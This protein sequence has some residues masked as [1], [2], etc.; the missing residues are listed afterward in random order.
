MAMYKPT[1]LREFLDSLGISPK[2]ALSQNFLIVANLPYNMTTP[3]IAR[4]IT[5][6]NHFSA[7]VVMVQ[8]EVARRFTASPGT[9]DYSSFTIFLNFY[10]TPRYAFTVSKNCFYPVPSVQSAVV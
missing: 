5:L 3:I 8:E 10:S 1:E 7:L 2:K 6:R 9:R 4:F